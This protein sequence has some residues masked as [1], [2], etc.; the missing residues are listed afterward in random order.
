MREALIRTAA[1]EEAATY[2][3][4]FLHTREPMR[5]WIVGAPG[6]GKSFLHGWAARQT[7]NGKRGALFD[8]TLPA[9]NLSSWVVFAQHEP[10]ANISDA[11]LVKIGPP[12]YERKRGV[13][14]EWAR[15][16]NL[17]WHEDALATLLR[18]P[19]DNLQRLRSLAERTAREAASGDALIREVDV[20]RTLA[21]LGL[22]PV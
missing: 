3:E 12:E 14:E 20:L 6:S 11:I 16:R 1:V 15:A 4:A 22:L 9:S 7:L 2:L 17:N 13:L 21:R 18:V 10:E 8:E 5:L 19:S